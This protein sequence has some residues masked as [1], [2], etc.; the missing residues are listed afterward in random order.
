MAPNNNFM[1]HVAI[2]AERFKD[3][4]K[5]MA[6]VES[7][8]SASTRTNAILRAMTC[9]PENRERIMLN[10]REAYQANAEAEV[11]G[12]ELQH[13]LGLPGEEIRECVSRLASSG[14][15]SAEVF[16]INIWIRLTDTGI[17]KA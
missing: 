12:H 13:E 6:R 1:V 2:L 8:Q 17:A 15:V 7:C 9:L 4:R 3:C 14:L 10:M 16:P 5:A 11:S